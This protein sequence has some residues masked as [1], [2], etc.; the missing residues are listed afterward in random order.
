MWR[1]KSGWVTCAKPSRRNTDPGVSH[2]FSRRFWKQNYPKYVSDAMLYRK[3]LRKKKTQLSDV[4]SE[5][6]IFLKL[7]FL[8]WKFK[9]FTANFC[10][11]SPSRFKGIF[12]M[13]LNS[14]LTIKWG[15]KHYV[16]ISLMLNHSLTGLFS[17]FRRER[18]CSSS[19]NRK[20]QMVCYPNLKQW[21][22]W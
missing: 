19:S 22:W 14:Y 21:K 17:S 5:F 2:T 1:Q 11:I 7:G 13:L 16:A 12:S 15:W 18:S 6:V 8:W 9:I 4:L 10:H 3:F 20:S